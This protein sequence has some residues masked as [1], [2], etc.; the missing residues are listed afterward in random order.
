M[1]LNIEQVRMPTRDHERGRGK[2][3]FRMGDEVGI[4]MRLDMVNRDDGNPEGLSEGFGG[5]HS[6][7]QSTEEAGAVCDANRRDVLER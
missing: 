7:E 5:C 2:L 6:D 3:H 1:A 4:Q